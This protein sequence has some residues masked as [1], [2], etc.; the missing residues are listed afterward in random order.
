MIRPQGDVVFLYLEILPVLNKGVLVHSHDIFTPNDY[1]FEWLSKHILFWNEQYL[2]E[3]FLTCNGAFRV[4]AGV[5]HLHKDHFILV[6]EKLHI[7]QKES[8]PS[9]FWTVKT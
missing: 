3:A 5:N 1:P 6:R 2:L 7:T 4:M 9:S 8:R